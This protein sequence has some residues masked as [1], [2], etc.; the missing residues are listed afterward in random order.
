MKYR[1]R[2]CVYTFI[3]WVTILVGINARMVLS[4]WNQVISPD[5]S[6]Y[7]VWLVLWASVTSD[8][9]LSPILQK[10]VDK[11]LD[12]YNAGN[13]TKIIVSGYDKNSEHLE[14]ISMAD[15]LLASDVPDQD[16][17][18]DGWWYDTLASIQ[19]VD[20]EFDVDQ[21]IVFTQ[22]YHLWRSLYYARWSWLDAVWYAV[23]DHSFQP[24]DVGTSRE[25]LA[26]IKA[27]WEVLLWT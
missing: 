8:G 9:L 1:F 3:L 25:I 19:R 18:I 10:R 22:R 23:D 12:M 7:N 20:S 17:L 16:I 24:R 2:R 13:I 14:A 5:Y 6:W 27:F 15:Y 4:S 11:A 26:R 21:I